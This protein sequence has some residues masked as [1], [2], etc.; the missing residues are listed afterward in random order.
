MKAIS[1]LQP[2]AELVVCGAKQW[3]T[4][5]WSTK[6]RGTLL[7]HASQKFTKQQREL[8]LQE[9]FR[10]AIN[11]PLSFGVIIGMVDLRGVIQTDKIKN[12]LSETETSFGDYSMGRFAWKLQEP[13]R[14]AVMMPAEGSLGL[15][16]YDGWAFKESETNLWNLVPK[17]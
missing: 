3:E 15:W 17:R 4:R 10:S 14:F 9:P 1:L 11:L 16:N 5:S 12:E 7:I 8:C 2:W 6:Y 13:H